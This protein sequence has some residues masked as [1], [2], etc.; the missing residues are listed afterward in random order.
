MVKK[1]IKYDVKQG[2]NLNYKITAPLCF[3]AL[4]A[5]IVDVKMI[6]ISN[7]TPWRHKWTP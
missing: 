2:G 1:M 5:T 7:L 4:I 3:I 6:P